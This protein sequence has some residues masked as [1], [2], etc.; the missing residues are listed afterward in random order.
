[1]R[2]IRLLRAVNEPGNRGPARGQFA[3]QRALRQVKPEWLEI[4]GQLQFGEIPWAWSYE[5]AAIVVKFAEWGFPFC[6]GPNFLFHSSREPGR[7]PHE[8]I[9][10]DAPSCELLF[11]ES[12]WYAEL[13]QQHCLRNKA[14]IAIFSYPIDPQPEGPLEAKRD[15]LIY[16]KKPDFVPQIRAVQ[17]GPWERSVI[18]TYGCYERDAMILAARHSR[19]CLYLSDDDR[20]PLALAEIMLAGC[21]AIGVPRGAPW[22]VNGVSGIKLERWERINGAVK[23]AIRINRQKVRAWAL[24]RFATTRSVG[25]VLAALEAVAKRY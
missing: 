19:A 1:M 13:I 8:Q 10:L 24:E 18:I 22:I 11:T 6:V 7:M 25:I 21:P 23:R 9:V 20:G 17:N 2:T 12:D 15:L 4:G 16:L 5:D 3:L 14:P